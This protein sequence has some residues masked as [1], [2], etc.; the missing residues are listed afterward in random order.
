MNVSLDILDSHTTA[1]YD[2]HREWDKCTR[3]FIGQQATN[4]V[5]SRGTLPC[6]ILF[7]GE[8]PGAN[9]NALGWPFVGQSGKM[10][11]EWIYKTC[12]GFSWAIT[13]L[14]CCRPTE[15][16][17]NKVRNRPPSLEEMRNC[18]PRLMEFL[19][20][21]RPRAV[22]LVGSYARHNF[23]HNAH[24]KVIAIGHPSWIL[25]SGERGGR[26]EQKQIDTI[27]QF[28]EKELRYGDAIKTAG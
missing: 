26:L 27:N 16:R 15:I 14:V 28:I 2:K 3:C 18:R 23:P 5:L 4:H 25:Q 12:N 17:H 8:G 6:D 13:N 24:S 21:A 11:N 20:I 10:L 1:A 19:G 22:V 9:E 7:V